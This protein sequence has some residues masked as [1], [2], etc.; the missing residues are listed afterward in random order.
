LIP[1]DLSPSGILGDAGAIFV[2]CVLIVPRGSRS[3]CVN[4]N[5]WK[6]QEQ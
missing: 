5:L 4:R 3:V 1:I 6:G 2:D